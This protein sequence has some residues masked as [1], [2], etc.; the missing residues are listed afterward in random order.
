MTASAGKQALSK[1]KTAFPDELLP[2]LVS[3]IDAL[4]TGSLNAIVDS[5]YLDLRTQ[6]VKKNAIEAKV[7]EVSEKHK[8]RKV[9][10]VREDVRVSPAQDSESQF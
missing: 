1:P 5:I 4:A 6:K 10:V 2:T 7:R 9:W 8:E 3:K